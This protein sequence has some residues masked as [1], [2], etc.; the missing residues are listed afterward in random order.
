MRRPCRGPV[1][2][3]SRGGPVRLCCRQRGKT[4][5]A[6]MTAGRLEFQ[7]LG[8]LTVRLNGAAIPLGGPKQRALLAL[9]LLSANRVVS[10]ERLIVELFAEQSVTSAEHALRN[11]VWRLRKVLSPVTTDEPRLVARPP[12]GLLG[13]CCQRK[14]RRR[15]RPTRPQPRSASAPPRHCGRGG[16]S[17]TSSSSRSRASR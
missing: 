15:G 13:A 11:Q 16:R 4:I 14:R 7:I 9:L 1:P 12:G 6:G 3:R 10:R 8:P 2:K 5:S 17:R